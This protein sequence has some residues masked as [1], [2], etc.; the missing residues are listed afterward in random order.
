MCHSQISAKG[1]SL[2]QCN[3]YE[4]PASTRGEGCDVYEVVQ[5][6]TKPYIGKIA[7]HEEVRPQEEQEEQSPAGSRGVI[8]VQNQRK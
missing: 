5:I 2:L 7:Q 6:R 3:A 4:T 1:K 8:E